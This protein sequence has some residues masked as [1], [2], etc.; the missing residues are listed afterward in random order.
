MEK[1]Q[2]GNS[3]VLD[4]FEQG[5][6]DSPFQGIA[7][8]KNLDI[9]GTP[10]QASVG[11]ETTALTKPPT[12][13]T[14]AYTTNT[15]TDVVTVSS[16]SGWYN[17]MAIT[18]NTV[19]T[20]TGI[21]TG[22][23]Y[24]VGDLS[25]NTFKLY[26]NPGLVAGALVD[27]TGSNG[28]GT[29]SSYTFGKPIDY[30]TALQAVGSSTNYTFILDDNG[31][32]WWVENNTGTGDRLTYLGND[33]L[34]GNGGRAITIWKQHII[35]FR[36]N[37]VDGL[38]LL[39]VDD[40]DDL[41][42][43]YGSY[44][45]GGWAYSW[46][47]AAIER[48][49]PDV[50]ATFVGEDDILYF[51]NNGQLGSFAET[52]GDTLDLDD[53]A[54]YTGNINALDLPDDKILSISESGTNLLIGGLRNKI[55]PWDRLSSSFD[56]SLKVPEKSVNQMVTS[57]NL[58]YIAAG[59]R[60]KIYVTNG[61]SVSLF[62]KI[63][64]HLTG[65]TSPYFTIKSMLVTNNK[66]YVSFTATK[67][68]G[69]TAITGVDGVYSIDLDTGVLHNMLTA[70][71]NTSGTV[72]L[73]IKNELTNTPGGNGLYLGW[74]DASSNYGV[75]VGSNNPFDG[76]ESFIEHD[77]IPI[78]T[79]RFPT[80][81]VSVEFKLTKPLVSGESV[82]I[83][84]RLN[85]TGSYTSIGTFN[86]VGA[87]SGS[88]DNVNFENAEWLQLK[89]ILTSTATTPSFVPLREVRINLS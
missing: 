22:R 16:T 7:N 67:N 20:S 74:T 66:L 30:A 59:Y 25:G 27:I 70:S 52:P 62:K 40:A 53:A 76:G 38:G 12:V 39:Q 41:D 64:D 85:L 3:I 6:A 44:V 83:Q 36:D 82:E 56:I 9:S 4:G 29:L 28:S 79:Y 69:T 89:T 26:K 84:R 63:P 88:F 32:V 50:R 54:S 72:N 65:F 31:R 5:I 14:L 47:V 42:S 80:N 49:T 35:V 34:S 43:A 24:W 8:L 86:T 33:T 17:T 58:I 18:L 51:A 21:S 68:D 37:D 87:I 19:V 61:S 60:G 77:I 71:H 78:G 10:G 11:Y 45:S 57:G 23:V 2:A 75:D 48:I 13:T 81:P 46:N 73:I 55:Y 1:T 15:A